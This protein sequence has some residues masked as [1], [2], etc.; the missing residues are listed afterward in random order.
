MAASE[1][2]RR[3]SGS[4]RIAPFPAE[5][6][7]PFDRIAVDRRNSAALQ[8]L[9]VGRERWWRVCDRS[10][11]DSKRERRLLLGML[12]RW[13]YEPTHARFDLPSVSNGHAIDMSC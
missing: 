5:T 3:H 6:L 7:R 13:I 11:R 1:L 8:A 9:R 4:R 2:A 12:L 10:I